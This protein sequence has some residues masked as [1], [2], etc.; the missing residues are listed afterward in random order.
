M[1]TE[2][3]SLLIDMRADVA[4]LSQDMGR[5]QSTVDGAMNN[6][7]AAAS[8]AATALG[9]IGVGVSVAGMIGL[10]K[11]AVGAMAALDD[12]AA[13]AGTTVEKFSALADVAKIGGHDIGLVEGA[14]VRLTKA[15]AGGDEEAK[16]AGHALAALG[17]KAEELRKMD[18]ADA[19]LKVAMALN[20]YENSGAKTTLMLDLLG[21]SGAAAIPYLEDLAEKGELV[22]KVTT[23]QAAAAEKLEKSMGAIKVVADD[24]TRS[25]AIPLVSALNDV[26]K[27]FNAARDAGY[28]FFQS[29]TGV[30]VRGLN[31]GIGDAKANAGQRIKELQEEIAKHQRDKDY[32]LSRGDK[33]AARDYDVDLQKAQQR[34]TYYKALQRMAVEE[35]WSGTGHLDA[36]D[37]R[38]R[39]KESLTGYESKNEKDKK[40][41]KSH[42]DPDGDFD[43]KFAVMNEKARRSGFDERDKAAEA[44]TTALAKLREKYVAMADPL[45]Q[46]RVQLDEIEKL[47]QLGRANGGIDAATA[48]EAEWAVNEAMDKTID[49]LNGVKDAG[50]NAFSELTQAV[51]SWGN[52][53]ADTFADF[54]VDGKASFGDLVNSMLKDIVRLQAK[55]MLDPITRGANGFLSQALSRMFPG[56]GGGGGAADIASA[57]GNAFDRSGLIPFAM[58]G[59]VDRPTLFPFSR[60]I[61][62]MGEAGPEAIL[63]LSRGPGGKLGVQSSGG[64]GITI[65]LIES[66]SKAGQVQQRQSGGQSMIDIFVAQI[67]SVVSSDITSG[68]GPIPAAMESTYGSNRAAGSY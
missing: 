54:V 49:K 1:A 48:L 68:R 35:Q 31:E 44:E 41:K 15:L 37:L 46:Y 5:V 50:K 56:F 18:T 51:E 65:N 55:Q 12:M 28:G 23:E 10:V 22:A 36:R 33:P 4:R 61:G 67:R 34:L 29:L 64:G 57:K 66:D 21:K 32:M 3:G 60:G 43:L 63:P 20:K 59:V 13:K 14:M 38:A 40:G 42:F 9:L 53:A 39:Q 62:L 25:L 16:G 52:K 6:V 11:H 17:L 58:G 2:I 30:G 24:L 7:K 19:M 47:K 45:Q 26:I 27:N 8:R